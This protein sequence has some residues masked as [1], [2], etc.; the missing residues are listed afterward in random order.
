MQYLHEKGTPA[1]DM[2]HTYPAIGRKVPGVLIKEEAG[3]LL[4]QLHGHTEWLARQLC[5]T[6]SPLDA[7]ALAS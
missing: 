3:G 1:S 4:A 5:G 6:A 7:L 2:P